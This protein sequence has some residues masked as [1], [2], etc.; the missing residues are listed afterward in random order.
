MQIVKAQQT[1]NGQPF[2]AASPITVTSPTNITYESNILTLNITAKILYGTSVNMTYIIDGKDNVTVP[3]TIINAAQ[4][5]LDPNYPSNFIA[6]TTMPEL[7]QGTHSIT[8]YANYQFG[9]ITGLDNKTIDF[10]INNP[11]KDSSNQTT[12]QATGTVT[13]NVS[14]QAFQMTWLLIIAGAVAATTITAVLTVFLHKK[15]LN[16]PKQ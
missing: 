8:V 1:P 13:P 2:I 10:T 15:K 16:N 9:S 11:S 14:A 5:N 7:S 6:M 3:V 12:A 4:A